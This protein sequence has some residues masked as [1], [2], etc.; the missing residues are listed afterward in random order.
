MP[1]SSV[2]VFVT[3]KMAVTHSLKVT[4]FIWQK[5]LQSSIVWV[6]LSAIVCLFPKKVAFFQRYYNYFYRMLSAIH[7]FN[8]TVHFSDVKIYSHLMLPTHFLS[9]YFRTPVT[10]KQTS[11]RSSYILRAP[12]MILKWEQ[13]LEAAIFSQKD[14]FQNTYLS[15]AAT[16]F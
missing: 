3:K 8:G 16:S 14:L 6:I 11:Y 9:A 7:S 15:G 5:N 2:S 4:V 12:S 1:W 13:P 10:M